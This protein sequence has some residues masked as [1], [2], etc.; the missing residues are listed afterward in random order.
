ML[1]PINDSWSTTQIRHCV[2]AD[3]I[4]V[5]KVGYYTPFAVLGAAFTLIGAVLF[6][7][8][9][10][11]IESAKVIG[12]QIIAGF[13]RGMAN[14]QPITAVQASIPA[15]MLPIVVSVVPFCQY[16][17]SALFVSLGTTVF[18]NSLVPALQLYAPGVDPKVVVSAG[19]TRVGD[20][21][22]QDQL[23]GVLLAANKALTQTFVSSVAQLWLYC[24]K[25]S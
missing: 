18:T 21:V 12:F 8:F 10:P 19:A 7:T 3:C 24:E 1:L 15:A 22:P 20:L 4:A 14:Q 16:F 23:P 2:L 17:G 9:T 11:S 5:S 6:T 25:P 13:G